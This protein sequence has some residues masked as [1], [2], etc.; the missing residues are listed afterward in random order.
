M[1]CANLS[2]QR[3]AS[4]VLT[5][6]RDWWREWMAVQ[7]KVAHQTFQLQVDPLRGGQ[8]GAVNRLA[9]RY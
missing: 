1:S 4:R 5:A 2:I 9:R 3:P 6:V 7:E 8:D